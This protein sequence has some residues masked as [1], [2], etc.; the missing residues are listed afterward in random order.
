MR[1]LTRL[2]LIFLAITG[3]L[4]L[5]SAYGAWQVEHDYPPIGRFV[6]VAGLRLHYIDTGKGA[7]VVLVHGAST[8]LRD[9][10]ASLV[11]GLSLHHRVLAFDRPGHGYS[12]RPAGAWPDPAEQARYLH[13]ALI[14][15]G[16]SRPLLV[17][18]SWSGSLVL[19]YLLNYPGDTAGGVLLAGGSHPWKGGVDWTNEVGGIPVLGTLFAHTLLFPAG[20]LV[21]ENAIA[22]VFRPESPPPGYLQRTGIRLVLRPDNYFANAEDLRRLSDYLAIQSRHYA[23]LDRPVLLIHGTEDGIVPAWNHTDRLL[24]ILPDVDV[25]RL[26]GAGHALHH[27]RTDLV[28][29]LISDFSRRVQTV[30][31]DAGE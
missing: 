2:F 14:E 23:Q 18:H 31:I 1:I 20:Q 25:V 4:A 8:T 29:R 10:T 9:F 30:G 19:A 12:E 28:A 6:D 3:T 26:A 27:T 17:G 13:T 5:Y 22:T 7:P 16:V 11:P 15:L 21:M 24:K